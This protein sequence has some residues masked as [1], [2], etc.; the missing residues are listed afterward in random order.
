M[1]TRQAHPARR[2]VYVAVALLI[3]FL[4]V[5]AVYFRELE[6]AFSL[7]RYEGGRTA[8]TSKPLGAHFVGMAVNAP[9]PST[10]FVIA[11]S[12]DVGNATAIHRNGCFVLSA[13]K[14][15]ATLSSYAPGDNN[16]GVLTTV[17]GGYFYVRLNVSPVKSGKPSSVTLTHITVWEFIRRTVECISSH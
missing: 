7:Y 14:P 13:A 9:L 8:F 3:V 6:L 4:A 5:G 12:G 1:D 11:D 16:V 10:L 15:H 17:E 2:Y